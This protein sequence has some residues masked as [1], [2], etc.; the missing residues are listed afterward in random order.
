MFNFPNTYF[1]SS[2]IHWNDFH[3]WLGTFVKKLKYIYIYI[4]THT[5]T[6][7]HTYMFGF[8]S[9][10]FICMPI[11]SPVSTALIFVALQ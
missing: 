1:Q 5:H 7:T 3:F 2:T 8:Y 6:H 10:S 4:Y 11:F 9:S